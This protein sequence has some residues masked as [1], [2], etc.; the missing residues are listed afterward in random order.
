MVSPSQGT[1]CAQSELLNRLLNDG[2]Q[3]AFVNIVVRQRRALRRRWVSEQPLRGWSLINVSARCSNQVPQEVG[4]ETN[5]VALIEPLKQ[6]VFEP[7]SLSG[8]P[9]CA[10]V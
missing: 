3:Q 2:V 1:I 7:L 6:P 4:C 9:P 5:R 8:A 10:S